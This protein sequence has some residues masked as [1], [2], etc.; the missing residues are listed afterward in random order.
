MTIVADHTAV[1]AAVLPDPVL[2]IGA[3][4]VFKTG[5]GTFDHVDP[6]TGEVL[7]QIPIAG[8]QEV[9]RAVA[10]AK[11]AFP[12]WRRMPADRRR[13]LMFK[14]AEALREHEDELK[15]I[16][17][18]ETGAPL[19]TNRLG[20]AIDQFEYY[21]G[22]TDKF[23]GELITSYP[24]RAFDYVSYE[25]YGVVGALV[26][27]NGPVINASMK[28]AP[29]IA[30]GNTVVLKSPEL[31]PFALIRFGEI[32]LEAG[33][34]EGVV[35]IVSGGPDTGTAIIA[36]PDV[37]KVSFTGGPAIAQQ[38]M[39]LAA[40]S[41]TPVC[42][43]LGGKSANIVFDDADLGNA[44]QMAALMSTI[45]SSGQGCLFPTR[46]F[47]QDSV[48]DQVLEQARAVAESPTIG[49]PLAAATVM[50]PVISQGA[51]DRILGYV[52]DARSGSA[53]LITGGERV[54]GELERG[55][56][57]RPTV[58]ADV[59]NSSRLAQEEIFG[60]VLAVLPFSTE[61]EVLAKANDTRYGLA[62]YV[63]TR[64]LVR[65]HRVASELEAGYIGV[66]S[67][68]SM[69]ASAPFGGT[70]HSG[71]GREGGRAGIEEFVHHK[72]VYIPLA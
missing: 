57:I 22:W 70:K 69:T 46:L 5:S 36:H 51:I 60:P 54:G 23:E 49:D 25:P 59:D 42:L 62:A 27:W 61:E 32:L 10:T 35:N 24:D 37:R 43:E 72:N 15:Q 21:A 6:T 30:A 8:Q 4:R 29:A 67:F 2:L 66:N 20:M 55:N 14:I 68:P 13:Y 17:A 56:F 33:L 58:F 9:D 7:G 18:L 45:A 50:G 26:T 65:A 64:D 53:R 47:V 34:P 16:M 12:A 39:T 31:G 44:A 11:A 40:Q 1:A 28:I 71:F 48:Y 3:D 38:V 52:E 63:H 19:A 41:L